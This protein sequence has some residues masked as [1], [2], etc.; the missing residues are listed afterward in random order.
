MQ[1]YRI[2][3]TIITEEDKENE[4]PRWR[5]DRRSIDRE[6]GNA[7]SVI[8]D[9]YNDKIPDKGYFFLGTISY[10]ECVYGMVLRENIDVD[11]FVDGFVKK[12]KLE[13]ECVE[14]KETTLQDFAQMLDMGDRSGYVRDMHDILREFELEDLVHTGRRGLSINYEERILRDR[15]KDSIYLAASS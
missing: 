3:M 12:A 15:D 2:M 6:L 9:R 4:G 13:T 7:I 14:I 5:P 8:C 1:F 11:K 10:G